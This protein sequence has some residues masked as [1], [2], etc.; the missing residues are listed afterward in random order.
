MKSIDRKRWLLLLISATLSSAFADALPE[1]DSRFRILS[2]N[3][4]EDAFVQHPQ[5]FAGILRRADPDILLFDEV[6]P[7][8]KA[9]KLQSVLDDLPLVD[10]EDW[11]IDIGISGGR[12]RGAIVSRAPLEPLQ[13]FS[14]VVPYPEADK[15]HI[16]QSMSDAERNSSAYSME[17]GIPVNG[18]LIMQDGRRLLVLII[19]LQCCG[20]T[21]GSWQEYRRRVEAR[22][23]RKLVRRILDRVA[24]DGIVVAGDFNAVNTPIPIVRLMGPYPAPHSGLLPAELYHL[25]GTSSWTWDGRGTPFSSSALDFQL[26]NP[27]AL[28]VE[29]GL[30][31]DTEDLSAADLQTYG[32]EPRTSRRLSEH[33]PL[34]VEYAWLS[35]GPDL[36]KETVQ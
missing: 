16:L 34:I 31:L 30:I 4:S 2:W 24:V 18:A 14:S 15:R 6:A 22:E 23:I 5:A 20:D 10:G 26:Y 32:L 28:C 29:S 35:A 25:D 7:N 1:G 8:V 19:D 3:I 11:H 13:E 27:N 17:F 9:S 33:R 12:Q 36:T 21:P